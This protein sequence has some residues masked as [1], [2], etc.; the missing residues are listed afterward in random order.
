MILYRRNPEARGVD[1][2]HNPNLDPDA[3]DFSLPP[4]PDGAQA[5]P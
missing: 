1:P 4:L 2:Y 5:R 3:S